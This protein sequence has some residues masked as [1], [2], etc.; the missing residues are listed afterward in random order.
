M[1]VKTL[2]LPGSPVA[3]VLPGSD[4]GTIVGDSHGRET[5]SFFK[6]VK[7]RDATNAQANEHAV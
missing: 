5:Q 1:K 2:D 6:I 7:P 4:L 3:E